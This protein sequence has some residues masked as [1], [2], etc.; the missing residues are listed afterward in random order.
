[1][2]KQ[3][4]N[5]KTTTKKAVKGSNGVA[6]KAQ[7]IKALGN[8]AKSAR[9]AVRTIREAAKADRFNPVVVKKALIEARS[10]LGLVESE[11][12]HVSA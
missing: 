12:R 5:Q 2:K 4:K 6:T 9:Q 10:S 1:M 7:H 11:L 8:A 3:S